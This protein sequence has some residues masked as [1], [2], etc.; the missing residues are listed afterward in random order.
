M[1]RSRLLSAVWLAWSVAAGGF[2]PVGADVNPNTQSGFP[3]DQAFQV[4]DVDSVN[5][6]NGT[7]VLTI[8]IGITYPVGG[9]LSYGFR[10]V[11]N[12]NPWYFQ[13][14]V[15]NDGSVT[16][17][18]PNPCSNAG[19]GWRLSFGRISPP[20][21][22]NSE[23]SDDQKLIYDDPS[24]AQHVFYPT[25]HPGEADDPGDTPSCRRCST[26][27]TEAICACVC[28]AATCARS[29]TPTARSTPSMPKAG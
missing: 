14:I 26:P 21:A 10:L 27:A 11:Y 7:L 15:S 19:L 6:F 9:G 5:L 28:S 13:E 25:L 24:G 20:C 12:S 3:V 8:P 29:T 23:F 4:G 16:Q 17:A 1:N 18:L 2:A 22:P